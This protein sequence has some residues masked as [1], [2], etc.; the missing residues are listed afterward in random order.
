MGTMT[1]TRPLGKSGIEVSAIGYGCMGQTHSYGI[2]EREEDS[3]FHD[4][5]QR[6]NTEPLDRRRAALRGVGLRRAADPEIDSGIIPRVGLRVPD[7]SE[8]GSSY[9]DPGKMDGG[10]SSIN[11]LPVLSAHPVYASSAVFRKS[12]FASHSRSSPLSGMSIRSILKITGRVPSLQ[13]V[14]IMRSSFVQPFMME[15]PCKAV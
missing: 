8:V 7:P 9:G 15:P 13:Q 6:N 14:I 1:K 4:R 10:D 3:L 5:V 2:V 11:C 12:S